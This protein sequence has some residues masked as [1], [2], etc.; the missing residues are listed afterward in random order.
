VIAQ[1]RI[2][3]NIESMGALHQLNKFTLKWKKKQGDITQ[4][5]EYQDLFAASAEADYQLAVCW[6]SE[7][8]IERRIAKAPPAC[9]R[10]RQRRSEK[11]ADRENV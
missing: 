8:T 4:N 6:S 10:C 2:E 11:L 5:E 9:T 3:G 7:R 1:A